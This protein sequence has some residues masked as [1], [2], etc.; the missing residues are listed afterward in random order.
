[1]ALIFYKSISWLK[2]K[3]RNIS[4]VERLIMNGVIPHAASVFTHVSGHKICFFLVFFYGAWALEITTQIHLV[5][6]AFSNRV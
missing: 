5:L 2:E 1:M 4:S 6:T 3:M